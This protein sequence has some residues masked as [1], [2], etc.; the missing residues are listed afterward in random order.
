MSF[1]LIYFFLFVSAIPDQPPKIENL[2]DTYVLDDLIVAQC[3]S[4]IGDPKPTI[5]WFVNKQPITNKL[6]TRELIPLNESPNPLKSTTVQLKYHVEKKLPQNKAR[7][8]IEIT[9]VS[10]TEGISP[11][12]APPM[13]TTRIINIIDQNQIVNNQK[14][15][16]SFSGGGKMFGSLG[17]VLVGLV[18]WC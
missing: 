15:L 8:T 13:N 14:L 12:V 10:H 4:G 18:M 16:S 2:M 17:V 1:K 9:C 6:A 3:I 11:I 5:T 7:I